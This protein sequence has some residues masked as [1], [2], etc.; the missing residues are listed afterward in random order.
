MKPK[1]ILIDLKKN[2]F[3][4]YIFFIPEILLNKEFLNN[5]IDKQLLNKSSYLD[6]NLF[7]TI[8]SENEELNGNINLDFVLKSIFIKKEVLSDN[9][10]KI[11]EVKKILEETEYNYILNNYFEFIKVSVHWGKL[12]Y[13]LSTIAYPN[14]SKSKLITSYQ[15]QLD[16]L[17][18]HLKEIKSSFKLESEQFEYDFK[19][20]SDF[21]ME[22]FTIGTV[23]DSSIVTKINNLPEKT[24]KITLENENLA[25][26]SDKTNIQQKTLSDFILHEKSKEIEK[27]IFDNFKNKKGRTYRCIYE[28]MSRQ[29]LMILEYGEKGK[30][31]NAFQNLFEHNIGTYQ[32][33]WYGEINKEKNNT[34]KAIRNIL[35]KEIDKL[36]DKK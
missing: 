4:N 12:Q 3:K 10:Y 34:Y 29:N 27:I 31:Y 23:Y 26:D 13:N 25:T 9:I 19:K 8:L 33:M 18:V 7:C 35:K 16:I 2:I 5:E 36:P 14:N 30:L 24:P 6:E 21:L 15:F 28:Y 1:D 11:F 22:L 32:S 20:I 17:N